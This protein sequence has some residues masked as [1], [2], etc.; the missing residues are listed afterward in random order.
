MGGVA[1]QLSGVDPSVA[2]VLAGLGVGLPALAIWKAKYGGY[3]GVLQAE[4]A[5]EVL[6]VGREER[7]GPGTPL[8][9]PCALCRQAGGA[10]QADCCVGG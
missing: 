7:A 10:G 2:A 1:K 4:E 6:Q 3:A 8:L 5:L 9:L